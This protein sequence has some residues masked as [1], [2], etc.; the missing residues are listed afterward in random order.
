MIRL[1]LY[2]TLAI[3]V[4]L[5]AVWFADH[6]GSIQLN[7]RGWEVRMSVAILCLLIL[8]YTA[9]CWYLFK[10]YRWFRTDNPLTSPKRLA[11]RREK[12][13]AELDLGWSAL[14]V[15]DNT[16]ALKHGKKARGLLPTDNGPLRLLLK[17]SGD[18]KYL[19]L[20]S[21]TSGSQML[22]LKFRLEQELKDQN[23]KNAHDILLKML[24]LSPN[25]PWI[26]QRL[27]DILTR[28]SKWADAD[29]ELIRLIKSKVIDKDEQ[30]YL[31][32]VLCFCQALEADLAGQKKTARSFAEQALK[33]DPTF[34]SAALL[35][36]RHHLREGD[37]GKA[38]KVIETVWKLAP[39]PDLGQF[40]LK[41]DPLESPSEKFRRL[42]KFT[43]LN[44]DHRHSLHLLASVALDTEH[45]VDA[46]QSLDKL[47]QTE[48]TS[49]ET[50][51][52]LARME[53]LQK[54]DE[55]AAEAHM[56]RAANATSDPKWQC[57]SCKGTRENYLA[58]CPDCHTFGGIRWQ[59]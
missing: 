35:L 14:A 25:S 5:G 36:A 24:A 13:L 58:T 18:E 38:G 26:N 15:H 46:K 49:R 3:V 1:G 48:Q 51:H 30:K 40:F 9:A 59:Q 10:L 45:W 12:G 39:H 19:D 16:A 22:T 27:F 42:Q 33:K 53:M 57:D 54:Q 32:A 41:L 23:S 56:A 55:K 43:K 34:I 47:V 31:T 37:K 11:S 29:Q 17:A 44:A 50:Y 4:A 21:A 6:P 20:L 2:I 28:R 8:L 52:L 7:W